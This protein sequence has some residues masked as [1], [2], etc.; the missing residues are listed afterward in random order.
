M[1]YYRQ[2][3]EDFL[4][5][6]EINVDRVLDI[7]GAANPIKNR[8]KTWNVKEYKIL[9][10]EIEEPKIKIDFKLDINRDITAIEPVNG[11]PFMSYDDY[12]P[13]SKPYQ[14]DMVFCLEVM[15]YVYNPIQAIKNIWWFTKPDGKAIITF[16]FVYPYHQPTEYDYLRYTPQGVKKIMKLEPFRQVKIIERKDKSGLLQSFYMADGMHPAKGYKHDTTGF[17]VIAI[18]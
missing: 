10:K 17:I 11:K 12:L 2:Q 18:K 13:P 16:P 15:E 6:V 5:L 3:L 9:D 8:V 4:K 14:F 7:G 1:S